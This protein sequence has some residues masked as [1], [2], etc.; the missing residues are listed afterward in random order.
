M[1]HERLGRWDKGGMV[2]DACAEQCDNWNSQNCIATQGRLSMS[3]EEPS[4]VASDK[5]IEGWGVT[6]SWMAEYLE[7]K[8]SRTTDPASRWALL[9]S[10]HEAAS[11]GQQ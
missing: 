1:L 9:S 6:G 2:D 4:K 3:D 7:D 8:V 10:A 5:S 11:N